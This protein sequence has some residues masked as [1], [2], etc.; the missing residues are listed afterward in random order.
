MVQPIRIDLIRLLSQSGWTSR[1]S[2]EWLFVPSI[3]KVKR[4][5]HSIMALR[6]GLPR[7]LNRLI[8]SSLPRHS[9]SND[10]LR[11]LSIS[12]HEQPK[13]P[14]ITPPSS[15]PSEQRPSSQTSSSLR[16]T[17]RPETLHPP[18]AP[19]RTDTTSASS[20]TAPP[21]Q[22]P[23]APIPPTATKPASSPQKP[24]SS[25][26]TQTQKPKFA[27][28][29]LKAALTLTPAAIERLKEIVDQPS[30]KLV[31]V[32]VKNRGC[33][34][35]AYHLEYVDAPGKFDEVV[36]QDGVK[37][38]ID[39]RALFSI[40]GSR[41]DFVEDRLSARFVFDNPHV[42]GSCGCGESFTVG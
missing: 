41:M 26:S 35:L 2:R 8:L 39:S 24:A 38:L 5:I 10:C 15:S 27:F 25:T 1:N 31:R 12:T 32:G 13:Q 6:S 36:E 7:H 20:L 42:K 22:S 34:G 33:A 21:D 18:P 9:L 14:V 29:P 23:N 11:T 4:R 28:K 30:P 19:P 17:K 16:E 37:V 40:I 3:A